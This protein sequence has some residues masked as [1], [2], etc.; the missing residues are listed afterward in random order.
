MEET[1]QQYTIKQFFSKVYDQFQYFYK[2]PFKF[3]KNEI[4]L[5]KIVIAAQSEKIK[6]YVNRQAEIKFTFLSC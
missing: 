5:K 6:F 2:P 1:S 4:E 3:P